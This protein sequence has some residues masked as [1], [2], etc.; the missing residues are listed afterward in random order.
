MVTVRVW[1][2]RGDRSLGSG[3]V[4][5]VDGDDA[6]VA[7]DGERVRSLGDLQEYLFEHTTPGDTAT[8]TGIRDGDRTRWR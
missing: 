6:I 2:E 3:W 8:L 7:I 5:A 4:Y 1:S